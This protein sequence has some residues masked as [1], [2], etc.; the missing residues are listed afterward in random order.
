MSMSDTQPK[1]SSDN[2][3]IHL[4]AAEALRHAIATG[5]FIT[6][7]SDQYPSLDLDGAYAIQLLNTR[8]RAASGARIVGSKIGLTSPA[9]QKQ[10]G[11]DQ[12]DFGMLFDDMAFAEGLPIPMSVL[13]QPKIEAEVAFVLGRD[14]DMERPCL[15]DVLRAIEFAL[16]ALEIV[17]SRIRDW[18]IKLADTV[19][20]NASASAFVLG[21]SPRR[22]SQLDLRNCRMQ[23]HLDG[24]GEPVSSGTGSACMAHPL[25]AVVWLARTMA[26]N[27][28]PLR[29]GHVVLSG[30]LG[31]M[32]P[33]QAGRSY[34]AAIEGLGS[35]MAV[36]DNL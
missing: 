3:A 2:S 19:A 8:H 14:L 13:Q 26:R 30:A 18:K 9:V 5:T 7:L 21:G 10:L 6:P 36:F 15:V 4:K 31:P 35:V 16:P 23:M 34:S 33:V 27:G 28:V 20:D 25:N 29:A 32:A 11:V 22:L 12:P 1:Q 24:S 17:G